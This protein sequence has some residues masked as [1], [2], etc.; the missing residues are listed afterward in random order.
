MT[1]PALV[2]APGLLCDPWVWAA[3]AR[4][5]SPDLEVITPDFFGHDSLQTMAKA[6]L[7]QAPPRFALA[8]HSMGARV[9]L[10]VL[11]LAPERVERLALLDTGVHPPQPG[12]AERRYELV[13]LAHDQ[14]MTALAARWLPPMLAPDRTGD[15]AL[16]ADLTAMV[17]RASPEIFER[18]VRALLDRPDGAARLPLARE[19]PVAVIVGRQDGWSPLAQHE[20]IAAALPGSTLTVIEDA[21]HM[22]LNE[23][24]EA[25][26]AALR[27]WLAR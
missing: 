17:E 14:G 22:S 4:D 8:G 24:P 20:D 10:E 1:R 13:H 11:A 26:T 3:Q 21:G 7:D 18:Q 9:A 25:V 16:M 12:E 6:V 5:L 15:A 19:M 27:A 2:L 23:Q